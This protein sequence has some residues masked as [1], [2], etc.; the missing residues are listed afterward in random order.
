MKNYVVI[1]NNLNNKNGDVS[2]KLDWNDMYNSFRINVQLN[3]TYQISFTATRTN[4]YKEA[5]DML[6]PGCGIWF[7]NQEYYIKQRE[8]SLDENGFL[9]VQVT[10]TAMLID[11]MKNVRI[12]PKQPTED[13]PDVSGGDSSSDSDSDDKQQIGTVIKQTD[14]QQTYTL[15]NRLDQFFNNNDQGIKYELHG[16]FPEVAVDCSGSLYEWLGSN[17]TSFGAYYIPDNYV[18]KIYDLASLQHPSDKEYRYLHNVTSVDIQ[19]DTNSMY[20]DFDVFGGK[21]EK[22]I[23]TGAGGVG[24]GVNEPVNGDWTPVIK[25]AAG[26]V[27][28]NLSQADINLVLAQINLES[29]GNETILGGTDGLADGRATGL[30]QYKPGTFNYYCRPPYTNIMHGLD[31]IIALFNVPGWRNQITGRHGWS[32][33][34][35]PVSKAPI[36][37]QPQQQTGAGANQIVDFCKSFVGKVPYVWGGSTTAGWDCSGFVCYVLNHFGINTPRT[38]TIGL[39]SKGTVVGPPYQTGDL[40]FWGPRGGSYHVSIAMDSTWRVGA[41]NYRDGTVYRTIASWPPSFA[42][43]VPQFAA[44]AGGM[45]TNTGDSTSLTT[46]TQTYYALHY[47]YR[48]DD[49]YKRIGLFRGPQVLVDSIYDMDA[50]KAYVDRTV[51]HQPPTSVTNNEFGYDEF[52]IGE[53]AHVIAREVN[54]DQQMTLMGI[55]YNPFNPDADA[56]LTWNN[57]AL[58]MK[59]VIYALYSSI[60]ETNHSI[61]N[62]ESFGA[63]GAVA[64]NHFKNI[65]ADRSATHSGG[66]GNRTMTFNEAQM[67][68]INEFVNS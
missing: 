47:H 8:F 46:T 36:Q 1:T 24:N 55:E 27:G 31:Q 18:L 68:A 37:Q 4:Q 5:F 41:D 42:V 58:A 25:N 3:S 45:A 9:T 23:T 39:E 22:D 57:T 26:L 2:E 38:N 43:R 29:G 13:S 33:H 56:S 19:Q 35:A 16:N 49:S 7:Q 67:K 60:N 59:D 53:T 10:A 64:E 40:L 44:L 14:K 48:D 62:N 54:V 63:L 6:Q 51:P 15:Q 50:L 12:D 30:L 61:T 20:N 34:G 65:E 52:S 11:L 28:E 32:P 17:L 21:M 66:Q